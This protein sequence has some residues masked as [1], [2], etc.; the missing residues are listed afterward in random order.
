MK[1]LV[2]LTAVLLV[3]AIGFTACAVPNIGKMEIINAAKEK[4]AGAEQAPA[5]Q[6]DAPAADAGEGAEAAPQETAALNDAEMQELIDEGI[7]PKEAAQGQDGNKVYNQQEINDAI[8]KYTERIECKTTVIGGNN[9]IVQVKN[10][11]DITI[12][13]LTV[14]VYYP[15]GEKAYDF[16]QTPA[17]R[18]IVIPV[19][20]GEGDLPPAVSA[21][22]SVS[23]NSNE[24][25]DLL[26]MLNIT[27]NKTNSSYMLTIANA[28]DRAC[29]KLSITVL[30]S[31][32]SGVIC[33]LSST[34]P[35][36]IAAGASTTF[37]FTL[38]Q[39]LVDAGAAFTTA[40]YTVNEA[41]G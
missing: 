28:A 14:H 29:R 12:P 13:K 18:Q 32:D 37:T 3:S 30:F 39:S 2:V 9:M 24:Y 21:D 7:V 23:M 19:E 34:A 26:P 5:E 41:L 15:E 8:K 10:N 40:S 16:C 38:P 35:D 33:A 6:N 1:K 31:D 20:K 36:S 4:A 11:N 27:E 22:V 17:G 25:V